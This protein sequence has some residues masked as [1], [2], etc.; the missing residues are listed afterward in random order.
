MRKL[1]L[2]AAALSLSACAT[3][4]SDRT[5]YICSGGAAYSVVITA[6]NQADV[7]AAGR[8]YMLPNTGGG[9]YSNGTVTYN[10]NGALT[11]AFG[12]P[13]ENCRQG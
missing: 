8:T 10:I 1:L 3:V 11:G 9:R 6:D 12:G 4:G 5:Q 7:F 2:A 13:Y